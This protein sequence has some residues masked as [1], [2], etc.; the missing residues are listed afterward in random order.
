MYTFVLCPTHP[1]ITLELFAVSSCNCVVEKLLLLYYIVTKY[2]DDIMNYLKLGEHTRL[3][4]ATKTTLLIFYV[5]ILNFNGRYIKP[6]VN[7][8]GSYN[9]IFKTFFLS[10]HLYYRCLGAYKKNI[11]LRHG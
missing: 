2:S 6:K 3:Y 9:D 1:L 11:L 8:K 5:S 10:L 4:T 7:L